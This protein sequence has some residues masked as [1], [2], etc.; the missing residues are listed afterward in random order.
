MKKYHVE[1][2][3]GFSVRFNVDYDIE[4][5]FPSGGC[6]CDGI[7]RCGIVKNVNIND[8]SQLAVE[9]PKELNI[10]HFNEKGRKV[11]KKNFTELEMYCFERAARL[12]GTYDPDNYEEV[13]T[14]GY[15]GEEL[16]DIEFANSGQL[17][18]TIHDILNLE[19]DVDKIFYVLELEYT[20]ILNKLKDCKQVRIVERDPN[21]LLKQ[22]T[23]DQMVRKMNL[24]GFPSQDN[25][26]CGIVF[27][28]NLID[29]YHRT[30][31]AVNQGKS[32]LKFIELS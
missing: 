17:K 9:F 5:G 12:L 3:R 22:T 7:C 2:P 1:F 4:S 13:V 27:K 14:A 20:Y 18:D 6:R 30:M 31:K 19:S 24:D 8:T 32:K 11:N 29:G 16:D 15:Y 21:E 28:D 25:L 23:H 10:C 26:P